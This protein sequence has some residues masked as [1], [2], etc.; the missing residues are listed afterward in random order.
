ML[1]IVTT[2]SFLAS[3]DKDDVAGSE[4]VELLSFGPTGAKP[5][6]T[7]RFFGNNLNKV[8]SIQLTGATVEQAGFLSQSSTEIFIVVPVSTVKGY[9]T[10]KAGDVDVVSKTQLDLGITPTVSTI[11]PQARPGENITITGNYLNWVTGVSFEKNKLVTTFISQ[12]INQIVVTVPVDAQTGPLVL[13]Y[14]G[15]KAATLQTILR[16]TL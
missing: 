8:T 7:L 4:N 12:T 9:V 10:L 2:I 6:D 14:S 3:C 13:N 11:T 1:C 15:T 16:Q 5:G